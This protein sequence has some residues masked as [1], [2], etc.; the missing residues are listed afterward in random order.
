MTRLKA[1]L[2]VIAMLCVSTVYAPLCAEESSV[3]PAETVEIPLNPLPFVLK[4][5]LRRPQGEGRFPAVVLLPACGHFV[6]SVDRVWGET[7]PSWGYVTLTLDV[8]TPRGVVGQETCLTPAPPELT[9]D[10]YRGLYLLARRK[11][12][13]AKHIFVVGFGRGG[14]LA[15]AAVERD[16][17]E[18]TAKRRFYG[19][20]A[21]YPPCSAV[22][23]IMTVATLVIVGARDQQTLEA[24]RKMADGEDDSGISRQP[25]AGEPIRLAVM[26]DAYAG[27]DLPLFEKATDTRGGFHI[28]YSQS[29]TDQAKEVL[30]Q[31]LQSMV[32]VRP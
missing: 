24:C 32:S 21:F 17:L 14:S 28:E 18:R 4:G 29:A 7:L 9:E 27:F 22:K 10:A 19:A 15:F 13:D 16:G 11:D 31:F 5:S 6:S 25:G 8:F 20:V 1:A 26:A 30:R 23:G 12:V 3:K 2:L